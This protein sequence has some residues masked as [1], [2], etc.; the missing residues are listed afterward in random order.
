MTPVFLSGSVCHV[1][2]HNE[3]KDP[4]KLLVK[5]IYRKSTPQ[6]TE[7]VA[8]TFNIVAFQVCT[9]YSQQVCSMTRARAHLQLMLPLSESTWKFPHQVI[10]KISHLGLHFSIFLLCWRI[11]SPACS[12]G[13]TISVG[14]PTPVFLSSFCPD[15][16]RPLVRRVAR[17]GG[18]RIGPT[19]CSLT[20]IPSQH[21]Q[22]SAYP[23][24]A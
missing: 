1:Y 3:L 4:F 13:I 2:L 22:S 10:I 18:A 6:M 20:Q 7:C 14:P 23:T 16:S 11:Y 5:I 9:K 8:I 12:F 19:I 17:Y 21:R 24:Y 15:K